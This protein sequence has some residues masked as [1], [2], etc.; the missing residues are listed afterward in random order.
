[1]MVCIVLEE[2]RATSTFKEKKKDHCYFLDYYKPSIFWWFIF[3]G[4]SL[5]YLLSK[6]AETYISKSSFMKI[7]IYMLVEP[8]AFVVLLVR[9]V[10]RFGLPTSAKL[11]TLTGTYF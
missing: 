11:P 8:R 2:W 9:G 5:F 4:F 7:I 10:E 3:S 1:M 6:F